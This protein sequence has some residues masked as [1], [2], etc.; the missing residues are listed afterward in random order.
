MRYVSDWDYSR[1]NDEIDAVVHSKL[2]DKVY[3]VE[4]NGRQAMSLRQ[5]GMSLT[6][7][8]KSPMWNDLQVILSHQHRPSLID[9]TFTVSNNGNREWP[10]GNVDNPLLIPSRVMYQPC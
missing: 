7:K 5:G 1:I 10:L 9:S 3:K 8:I 6:L 2:N 4:L